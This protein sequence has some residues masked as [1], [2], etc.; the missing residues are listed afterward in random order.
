[1][2]PTPTPEADARSPGVRN[3]AATVRLVLIL[4]LV[5]IAGIVGMLLVRS[6]AGDAVLIAAAAAPLLYGLWR[7]RAERR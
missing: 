6:P 4:A 7:W 1:M 3:G 5:S 2:K